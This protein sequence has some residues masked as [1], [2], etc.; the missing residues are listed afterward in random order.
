M[1]EIMDFS[2]KT[3]LVL[4]VCIISLLMTGCFNE[5]ES[6]LYDSEWLMQNVDE[7]WQPYCHQLFLKPNH[8]VTMQAYYMNSPTVIVWTGK[9]KLTSNKLIFTFEKCSR[10][11]DG[12]NTG[13]Y[14]A[15]RVIKYFQGEFFYSVGLVGENKDEY[16]LEL[17]RPKNFFYGKNLDFFG[18]PMEEFVRIEN[19]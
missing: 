5:K 1:E 19:E 6:P 17:I 16:H 7:K 11:E 4:L 8:E 13:N 12:V 2:R 14:K 18:N 3:I 9:Y 15:E 10:F